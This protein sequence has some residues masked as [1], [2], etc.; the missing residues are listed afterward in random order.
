MK[1]L[2]SVYDRTGAVEFAGKLVEAGFEIISTGGTRGELTAAGLPVTLLSDVTGFPEILDGRV[3]TLHPVIH[4]GILARRDLDS[5][6]AELSERGIDGI[7]VVVGNLYPFVETIR[8]PGVTL[9]DALENIDI[10]GPTMIRAAAKNFPSVI[11][12]VDPADYGWVGE[13]IQQANV[14]TLEERKGLALKA[15]RHVAQ[16]DAAV[17]RYLS[18]GDIVS[19]SDFAVGFEKIADMRY[20]ENPHQKGSVYRDPLG[21]GGIVNA[22]RLHGIEMSFTNY[23]DAEAAWSAVTDFPEAAAC[24]VKHLNPCGLSVH[25][26]Q[27]TAYRRALEGDPVSAYGGIVAYNRTLTTETARAMRGVLYHVIVAPDYEPEAL[28]ILK[29]RKETRILKVNAT[30]GDLSGFDLRLVSGG[31]L[32]QTADAIEEDPASWQV[33]TEREP[34][35]RELADLAFAWR[36]C[37]HIKSNAIVLGK[38]NTLVG[39]GTGQPNRVTSIRLAIETA[40]DKVTGSALASD[41]FM[42][43]AD[44]IE[45]AAQAGVA[46]IAQPGGSMRDDEVIEAANREGMTMVFTGVRHF[47]H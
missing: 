5:H 13:R 12:I 35:E 47:R 28:D 15:F 6:V 32:L 36:V 40:G 8:K 1:A 25:D 39:M 22:E 2:I 26:D 24:I 21:S 46:S 14:L 29:R 44:N 33:V 11:V 43:F 18:D 20:G 17:S 7:D 16:Y 34:T 37:K 42:P 41:A 45:A 4:A 23:L 30:G 10:G 27:P 9:E 19:G 38:D 31:A 3:K